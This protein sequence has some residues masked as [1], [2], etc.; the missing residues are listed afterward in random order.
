LVYSGKDVSEAGVA[1]W[2]LV[3]LTARDEVQSAAYR[4]QINDKLRWGQLPRGV[5]YLV[6]SDPPGP[7]VGELN[8]SL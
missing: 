3:V 6:F 8:T 1:F 7:K 2:D 5:Q 4:Q